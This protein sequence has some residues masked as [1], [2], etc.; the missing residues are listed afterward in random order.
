MIEDPV[1]KMKTIKI[2]LA[3]S[4]ELENDRMAFGNLVRRLDKIYERR[5]IRVELFEWEDYDSSY[6]G[7]RKQDEYNNQIKASDL[8]LAL[9][10]TQAGRFTIEEFDVATEEFRHKAS[11]KVYVYCKDLQPGETESL[12]LA[13]FK[14]RL[15]EEM[16]H[17]WC[18]Y[19]NRD[20]MQLHFVMQLQLVENNR[21]NALT[22]EQSG[23]VALDGNPIA[24]IDKLPFASGNETY[25]RMQ[26]ELLEFPEKI[27]KARQRLEKFPDD[28][29]LRDDLQDKLNRYNRL[30]E[31]FAQLQQ[32]LFSTAKTIATMQLEH[33]SA[34]L[35][36]AIEAF[37]CGQLERANALLGELANEADQHM[38]RLEQSRALVHQDIEAFQL[39]ARIV[40]ADA[41]IPINDRIDRVA[42]I[43]AKADEWA[44][45][46]AYD[47]ENYTKLLYDYAGF[48][49]TYARYDDAVKIYL[50]QIA[51]SEEIYGAA[52]LYTAQSYNNIGLVYHLQG[53]YAKAL[54]YYNMALSEREHQI[55]SGNAVEIAQSYN[56]IAQTDTYLG[57]NDEA[58]DFLFKAVPIWENT[59]GKNHAAT[60][61]TYNNIGICYLNK[62]DYSK[63]LEYYNTSLKIRETILEPEHQDIAQSYNNIGL[64]YDTLGHYD[65]AMRY[66]LKAL[67]I[68]EKVLG[69]DHPYT[70]TAINNIGLTYYHQGN[71]DKA[72]EYYFKDLDIC[73]HMLGPNHP[74]I[75]MICNNIGL[76]YDGLGNYQQAIPSY[77]K[78]IKIWINAF[79]SEHANTAT[80]YGNLGLAYAHI[81]QDDKALEFYQKALDI[82]I[83]LLGPAHPDNAYTYNNIA[84]AFRR[85]RD[86]SK[87]ME[88]YSKALTIF[89]NTL[90]SE[91]QNTL[92]VLRNME[93]A[94]EMM[95]NR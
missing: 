47:K 48:L 4:E 55:Q 11:P 42:A 18:R 38:Q 22:V 64:L 17:Y 52:H 27:E 2:F 50:R 66:Y 87:A 49:A 83:H 28:T 32:N 60:A 69:T 51:L 88:F 75:A 1:G 84:E 33:V 37:E 15:F 67:E 16:G 56:N 14:K 44:E 79:G 80:A 25:R 19:G 94:K 59:V 12:E 86:F 81:R 26:Q 73:E 34:M 78:A 46:S 5:G 82:Q 20:T 74:D 90:G 7:L 53:N 72:L 8:F 6:N 43:Y 45:R 71:F 95:K 13:E 10:H 92:A 21:M 62:G 39:Q 76:A 23:T 65:Q 29:D 35:R 63:A 36:R 31:E 68:N 3:S 61:K 70:A 85:Q 89:E 54:E 9:F 93:V 24:R 41:T 30:K 58:L 40:M 57:K 77:Q 91:H